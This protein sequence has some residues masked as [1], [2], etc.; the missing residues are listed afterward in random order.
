MFS[1]EE[2]ESRV[3]KV[4]AGM[5]EMGLSALVA[6]DNESYLNGGNVRYLTNFVG[7]LSPQVGAVVIT[8][9]RVTLCVN[10]GH[11]GSA[12]RLA[13]QVSWVKDVI[14]T[15]SGLWGHSMA[16]DIKSALN[17]AKVI[18]GRI[19]ID[20]LN[21]ITEPV[22]KSVRAALTDFELVEN[23]GIIDEV[24]MIKSPAEREVIREAAR[25]ADLGLEAF[26]K[27]IKA[28]GGVAT[29]ISE[30]EHTAKVHG[31]ESAFMFMSPSDALFIWGGNICH[32][33]QGKMYKEG[34][35]VSCEFNAGFQGYYGQVARSFVIGKASEKQKRIYD[36]CLE[37]YMKWP[38]VL[39]PGVTA[40]EVFAAGND[41]I[42]KAGYEPMSM[43]N[44]HGMGLT[45]AEGFDI[46]EDDDTEIKPGYYVM[47]HI[48]AP[49][50][51]GGVILGNGFLVTETGCEDL[52]KVEFRLEI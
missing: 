14:G 10:P 49:F 34:D 6:L 48:I 26:M 42:K 51:E 21:L 52:H 19:G 8:P 25:L 44:G 24:R 27:A 18:P 4:R 23:T 1:R 30:G 22:A 17:K 33:S 32:G 36:T 28:G 15:R 29:S 43:R 7:T 31:A 45:I 46:L 37:A 11:L 47:I 3:N 20:G 35:M 39:K 16:Q 12:F 40:S 13:N 38:S 2:F 5:S 9:E 41:V 50:D